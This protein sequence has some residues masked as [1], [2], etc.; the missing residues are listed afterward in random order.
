MYWATPPYYRAEVGPRS[1]ILDDQ[2]DCQR[3]V[4]EAVARAHPGLMSVIRLGEWT[5]PTRVCLNE[6]D[7]VPLRID[8]S[9]FHG[10]GAGLANR[11][12]L[13]QAFVTAPWDTGR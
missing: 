12:M 1:P 6:R 10:A 5:C 3:R 11:W 2:I 8:G 4:I 7:G 13:E 9:H